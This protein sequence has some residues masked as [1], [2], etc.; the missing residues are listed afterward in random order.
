M[1]WLNIGRTNKQSEVIFIYFNGDL[2]N[3]MERKF[4]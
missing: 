4:K 1:V 2:N 3:K